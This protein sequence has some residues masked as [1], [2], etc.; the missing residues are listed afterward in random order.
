MN[1]CHTKT[2]LKNN[3]L[4]NKAAK[5]PTKLFPLFQASIVQGC[6]ILQLQ[7]SQGLVVVPSNVGQTSMV[8]SSTTTTAARQADTTQR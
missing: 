2:F 4:V 5:F 1:C 7:G 6:S 8:T 3:F